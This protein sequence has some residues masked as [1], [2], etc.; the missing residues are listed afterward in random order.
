MF[1]YLNNLQIK[2]FFNKNGMHAKYRGFF[3]GK[4]CEEHIRE[5]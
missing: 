3:N 2:N 1:S 5:F 4:D